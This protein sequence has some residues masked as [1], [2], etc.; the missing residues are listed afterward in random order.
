MTTEDTRARHDALLF[1]RD[2]ARDELARLNSTWPAWEDMTEAQRDAYVIRTDP[3]SKR[4]PAG[5]VADLRDSLLIELRQAHR[6]VY[7]TSA[8]RYD[9]GYRD[10]LLTAYAMLTAQAEEDIYDDLQHA[11]A[12]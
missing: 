3:A 5:S 8:R 1:E 4:Y 10:G 11:L 12:D 6:A 2:T 9:Y 7:R